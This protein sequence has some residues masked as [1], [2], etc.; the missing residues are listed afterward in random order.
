MVLRELRVTLCAILLAGV[1]VGLFLI[2][3]EAACTV[4]SH[5][6]AR[7]YTHSKSLVN[8]SDSIVFAKYLDEDSH[9]VDLTNAYDGA[10]L[11]ELTLSV[12]K[13]Q[14]IEALKGHAR[15]GDMTFVVIETAE[16]YNW[17][18][19]KSKIERVKLSKGEDYVIF[20]RKITDIYGFES[21]YGD[22]VWAYVGR[23][24]VAQ[25]E[26]GTG[27]LQFK[28]VAVD[29]YKNLWGVLPAGS[30]TPFELNKQEILELVSEETRSG[31][32]S[33]LPAPSLQ[34]R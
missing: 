26:Q 15:I 30:Y 20:L 14:N 27:R 31:R 3:L 9:V 7:N 34:P 32:N 6:E 4:T 33:S 25:I 19:G 21:R 1:L 23:P 18:W 22:V 16:S 28:A 12:L 10:V 17:G 29:S 5:G 11:G 13:F 24:G 8:E 2:F